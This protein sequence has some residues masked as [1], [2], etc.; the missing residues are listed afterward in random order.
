M[1]PLDTRKTRA[2]SILLGKTDEVGEASK[3]VSKS[4]MYKGLPILLVRTGINN[5]ILLSLYEFFK[6][7]I[8]QLEA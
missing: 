3:A 4:S 1:Y 8:D 5:M 6:M 7:R 2:Q